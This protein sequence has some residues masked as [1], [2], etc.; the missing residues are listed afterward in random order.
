MMT[1][2]YLDCCILTLLQ[3]LV[4]Y[5]SYISQEAMSDM[6]KFQRDFV[7]PSNNVLTPFPR[8]HTAAGA[9]SGQEF[10]F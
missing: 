2:K 1:Q 5:M 4:K 6:L 7:L 9:L 3:A 8:R 10:C